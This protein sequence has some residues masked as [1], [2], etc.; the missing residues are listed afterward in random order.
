[1]PIYQNQTD[2]A[3]FVSR[4][5]NPGGVVDHHQYGLYS[6]APD[7][8]IFGQLGLED[9]GLTKLVGAETLKSVVA[10]EVQ[11]IP[12]GRLKITNGSATYEF[13]ALM[14]IMANGSMTLTNHEFYNI[15]TNCLVDDDG[16]QYTA[17]V[18][19]NDLTM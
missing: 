9:Q 12:Y 3:I 14:H 7:E 13:S 6:V 16:S 1:M 19:P 11:N 8:K 4:A 5:N 10:S 15:T 17:K 2:K 18:K